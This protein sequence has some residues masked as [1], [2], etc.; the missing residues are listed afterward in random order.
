[1][2]VIYRKS[3]NGHTPDML[4][5]TATSAIENAVVGKFAS[6]KVVPIAAITDTP[7]CITQGETSGSNEL[8]NVIPW[9]PGLVLEVEYSTGT[10]ALGD[11]VEVNGGGK[12]VKVATTGTV[13]GVVV[14]IG[15]DA[16][17]AAKCLIR[18]V[19]VH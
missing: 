14:A 3:F 13:V 11:E 15:I 17:A 6:D 8:V 16:S 2:S 10:P 5:Y 4:T 1:M 19:E 12:L 18:T 9:T 7:A